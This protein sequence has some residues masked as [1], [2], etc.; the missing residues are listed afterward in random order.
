MSK[1][2]GKRGRGRPEL[3]TGNVRKHIVAL[4]K[5][6]GATNARK[7]LI[8]CNG[9]D[10]AKMRSEKTVKEPLTISMPTILK[11][12]KAGGVVLH[13]GRPKIKMAKPEKPP[14][15]KGEKKQRKAKKPVVAEVQAEVEPVEVQPV[16]VPVAEEVQPVAD[17][18]ENLAQSVDDA[19]AEAA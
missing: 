19:V 17:L 4:V 5:Q 3:Y 15:E 12:A 8:A 13:R 18:G 10:E 6:H 14:V 1:E 9:S 16:E 11:L 7:I 2:N